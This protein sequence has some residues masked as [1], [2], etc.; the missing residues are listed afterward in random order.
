MINFIQ[1]SHKHLPHD[2][3]SSS[4]FQ[5]LPF[6]QNR[7]YGTTQVECEEQDEMSATESRQ[8]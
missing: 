1:I 6:I 7:V 4:P 5:P 8:C 2:G 3:M